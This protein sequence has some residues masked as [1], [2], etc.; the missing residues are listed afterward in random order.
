MDILNPLAIIKKL[1]ANTKEYG[2]NI[3]STYNIHL[4]YFKYTKPG[5][6]WL[7]CVTKKVFIIYFWG[8]V[9]PPCSIYHVQ[10]GPGGN[11]GKYFTHNST[12]KL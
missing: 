4:D 12:E 10:Y 6:Y 3:S 2:E 1:K 9:L 11:G 8:Q 7:S 5:Q